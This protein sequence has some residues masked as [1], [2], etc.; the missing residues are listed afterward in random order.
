MSSRGSRTTQRHKPAERRKAKLVRT[1][2]WTLP[3]VLGL[4]IGIV[5]SLGV[6]QLRPQ[7]AVTA[8][9]LLQNRQPYSAPFRVTNIGDLPFWV[10]SL[11][12]SQQKTSTRGTVLLGNTLTSP[13]YQNFE[14]GPSDSKT[15]TCPFLRSDSPMKADAQIHVIYRPFRR[16]PRSFPKCFNFTGAFID[17]WQ[18][19]AEPCA[20]D[21]N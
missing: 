5:G 15:I 11:S 2:S 13:V 9:D 20:P 8:Q 3:T 4:I 12:C 17:N 10:D 14:L 1:K 16:F 21:S 6:I 7:I 19:L 18:W